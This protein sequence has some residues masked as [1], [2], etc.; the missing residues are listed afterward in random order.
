[1][2]TTAARTFHL[3]WHVGAQVTEVAPPHRKGYIR[4]VQGTGARARITV[5]FPGAAPVTFFP[6]ELSLT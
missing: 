4:A 5:V 2:A 6:A 3:R 1:M